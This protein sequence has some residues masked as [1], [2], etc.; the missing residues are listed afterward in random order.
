[1]RL[2][3]II[4]IALATLGQSIGAQEPVRVLDLGTPVSDT[5]RGAVPELVLTRTLALFNDSA[6]TRLEGKLDLAPRAHITGTLALY[7]NIA[8]IKGTV[9]GSVI[10]LNGDLRIAATGRVEGNIIVLGGRLTVA[11]GGT[12]TGDTTVYV[13]GVLVQRAPDGTVAR[14]RPGRALTDFT[15]ASATFALGP[16]ATTLR[17]SAGTYNRTEGLPIHGGPTFTWQAD[18]RNTLRLDLAGILRT[19]SSTSGDRPDFGWTGS[20]AA[21]R[22]GNQP[23][24]IGVEAGSVVAPMTDRSFAPLESG[25]G[26]FLLRRDY[27]D[28]YATRG[29]GAFATWQP[30]RPL[31]VAVGLHQSRE[32]SV[33]ATDAF[34]LFRNNETWRANPLADDGKFQT[35][36]LGISYDSRDQPT[37]PSSGWWV[38]SELR[39]ITSNELTPASLPSDIRDALPTSGY[40][41]D[42]IDLDARYYLRLNPKH[43]VHL[44][45]A[46]G[47]WLG[48]DPLL[49]QHRRSMSGSDPMAG[50]GFRFLNC[51]RR[52]R[53]DAAQPALCD[54]QLLLQGEFRRALDLNLSTRVGGYTLG[55]QHAEV[56]LF[57]DLGTAWLAGDGKGQVPSNRIQNIGEWRSAVGIGIDG[58]TLGVYLAKAIADPEPIRL[59]FRLQRRF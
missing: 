56:V 43:S 8:R 35:A 52:R 4:L 48:G 40:Q 46:G 13:R 39:R 21:H 54:R 42:E 2:P 10:V 47:G 29:W 23:V 24:T 32:R 38:R 20:L 9:H 16:M 34:S 3:L 12:I 33:R 37:R 58:G 22:A 14:R 44:R 51:D 7:G 59:F 25:L 50:Y 5:S 28:W 26:A 55:I 27:R 11:R 18:A 19:A 57:G 45:V 41:A 6:T 53:P 49:L 36:S 17:A 15:N 1:M 31:V 30:L